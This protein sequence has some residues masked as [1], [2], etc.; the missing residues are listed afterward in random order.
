MA[1]D[2]PAGNRGEKLDDARERVLEALTRA[3]VSDRIPVEEYERRAALVQKAPTQEE[4]IG[5]LSDL[6]LEIPKMAS[7]EHGRP[8]TAPAA[9]DGGAVS[10]T[11]QGS[12]Q[13]ILCVMGERQLQG[14][15]LQG[16]S[17]V[18]LTIMGTTRIDLRN[19]ALPQGPIRIQTFVLMGETRVIVPRNLPV[20]L[21]ASPFMGE[22]TAKRGVDQ[23]VRYGEPH[24]IIEGF[25]LMGSLVVVA[26]D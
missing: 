18:S 13:D 17:A 15:W 25:V 9:S 3:Y 22:A 6:P 11:S 12:H 16:D 21:N 26:E 24:V 20:R 4:L 1:I 14:N 7:P 8:G 19:V 10:G 5:L 23:N 2:M